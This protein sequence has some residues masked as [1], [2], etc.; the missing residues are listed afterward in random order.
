ME[1][2]NQLHNLLPRTCPI[3]VAAKIA[4]LSAGT[5]RARC[6][7]TGT[8]ATDADTGNVLMASLAAHL[9]RAID[10]ADYLKAH[11][12]RDAIRERQRAYQAA[13]RR[14]DQRRAA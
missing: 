3:V 13:R 12:S 5:F 2:P 1:Q 6:L 14:A 4:G 8:V 7:N 11:R 10:E 9:G